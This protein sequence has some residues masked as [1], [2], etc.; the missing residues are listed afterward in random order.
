MSLRSLAM[1][2]VPSLRERE[3][4][5]GEKEGEG[6]GGVHAQDQFDV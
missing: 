2:F 4:R 3:E 1:P 5:K 6:D